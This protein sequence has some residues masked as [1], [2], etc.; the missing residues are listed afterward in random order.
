MCALIGAQTKDEFLR[1]HELNKYRG[2]V[3]HSVAQ[4]S[5]DEYGVA[6]KASLVSAPGVLAPEV[7]PEDQVNS[8]IIG[9]TQAPTTGTGNIHP[10]HYKDAMLWH[11]GIIKQGQYESWDTEHI[12]KTVYHRGFGSL[13]DIDG[14]FACFLY[15][16]AKLYVFRNEISPLFWDHTTSSFSSTKTSGMTAVNPNTVYAIEPCIHLSDRFCLRYVASFTTKE[17]PYF[18]Q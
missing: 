5:F 17:N 6:Q 15:M 12:L 4:F 16:D 14:T 1:L 10:A 9:H 13:S 2:E 11:N 8:L 3:S 7:V 18:F